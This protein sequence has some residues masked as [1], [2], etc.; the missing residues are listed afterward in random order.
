MAALA[1]LVEGVELPL[2]ILFAVLALALGLYLLIRF[3]RARKEAA[4]QEAAAAEAEAAAPVAAAPPPEPETVARGGVPILSPALMR[5]AFRN[6]WKLYRNQVAGARNPYLVPWY[7]AV[8]TDGTGVSTLCAGLETHRAPGETPDPLTGQPVGCTWWYHDQAV[9]IDVGAEAFAR[10]N[11]EKVPDAAWLALLEELADKRPAQPID[12]II[13]GIPVSDLM[14]PLAAMPHVLAEKAAQIYG[15]L[16]QAQKTLGLCLPV[17]VAVTHCDKLPGFLDLV[18]KLPPNR[19]QDILGWSNPYPLETAFRPAMV[20]EGITSVQDALVASGLEL[21][22]GGA[23]PAR[24]GGYLQV[25]GALGELTGALANL[26]QIVFRRTAYQEM[27]YFRGIYFVG[28][29]EPDGREEGALSIAARPLAFARDLFEQKIFAERDLTKPTQRWTATFDRRQ[30]LWQAAAGVSALVAALLLWLGTSSLVTQSASYLPALRLMADPVAAARWLDQPGGTPLAAADAGAAAAIRALSRVEEAWSSPMWPVAAFDPLDDK[31]RVSLSIAHYRLLMA[32]VRSRLDRRAAAIAA[33]DVQAPAGSGEFGRLRAYVGEALLLERF[34]GVQARLIQTGDV[35]GLTELVRYTHGIELP[36]FYVDLAG[37][38]G[39]ATVPTTRALRGAII[40]AGTKPIDLLAI[41]AP[42]HD[43]LE[44]LAD[45]YFQRLAQNG[46][47]IARMR[48]VATEIDNLARGGATQPAPTALSSI[49]LGLAQ[50]AEV[51]SVQ[52][53]TWLAGPTT[54]GGE[55]EFGG[56]ALRSLLRVLSDSPL[57]GAPARARVVQRGQAILGR[58]SVDVRSVTSAI[59]PLAQAI[60]ERNRIEL[61]PVAE[62][63]RVALTD[64]EK[65]PFMSS[66]TGIAEGAALMRGGVVQWDARGL[67]RAVALA[68][69]YALFLGRDLAL[70]PRN[71]QAGVRSVAQQRLAAGVLDAVAKA[72]VPVADAVRGRSEADMRAQVQSALAAQPVIL[73]L[74]QTLRQNGAQSVASRLMDVSVAQTLA[75]LERLDAYYLGDRPYLPANPSLAAWSGDK[76]NVPAVYGVADIGSIAA[77]LDQTKT[78][79]GAVA[80]ELADP[81]LAFLARP[82]VRGGSGGGSAGKWAR[83]IQEMEKAGQMR[84]NASIPSLERFITAELPEAST[85]SCSAIGPRGAGSAG[86]W[87]ADQLLEL[88]LTLSQLCLVAADERVSAAYRLIEQSF[89]EHVA[90]RYPFAAPAQA[91]TGPYATTEDIAAFYKAFDPV[92]EALLA[93]LTERAQLGGNAVRSQLAFLQALKQARTFLKP[94]VG[95]DDVQ[96]LGYGLEPKFRALPEKEVVGFD[97]IEWQFSV[98]DQLVDNAAN[99]KAIVWRNGDPITMSFRWARNAPRQPTAAVASGAVTVR[100]RVVTIT[101]DGPWALIAL[102]QAHEPRPTDWKQGPGKPPHMLAIE[103][104]TA[105]SAGAQA[106]TEQVAKVFIDL[107]VK[108]A[109][110]PDGRATT[111]RLGAPVFP[112]KAPPPPGAIAPP[113]LLPAPPSAELSGDLAPIR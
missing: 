90:G 39:F 16:W 36:A 79:I 61:A 22:A 82:E 25:P 80:M 98:N 8:G 10:S 102:L 96:E 108:G 5:Q 9:V 23:M 84:P 72:Q 73:R 76:V 37:E 18:E 85:K 6:G 27:L 29:S 64:L 110:T 95:L 100:D 40:D 57:F 93:N 107:A 4:A 53:A 19:R 45:S 11:G 24:G 15:R 54:A 35:T 52:D 109:P 99:K 89:N 34:V 62:Q 31:I 20:E 63:F 68:E 71:V 111:D 30:M 12:G 104:A 43:R 28:A 59:G 33:G 42:L 67:E 101:Q 21:A 55:E 7:L 14:G 83:I 75:L 44:I 51:L 106:V 105:P 65:R 77:M 56:S 112:A 13:L 41:R 86:D 48:L 58:S 1:Q 46:D 32:D 78:R 74:A 17:W 87:F 26:L 94:M 50:A 88:R 3:L 91:L 66:S 2:F 38:L 60:P 47:V 49:Q 70:M 69:D 103:I 81:L 97:I 113:V 92:Q